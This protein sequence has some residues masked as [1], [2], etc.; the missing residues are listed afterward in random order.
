MDVPSPS[1]KTTNTYKVYNPK[2]IG[3][4]RVHATD[5]IL[6]Y[7]RSRPQKE[8]PLGLELGKQDWQSENETAG[9]YRRPFVYFSY[10]PMELELNFLT[11]K[12]KDIIVADISYMT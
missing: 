3:L 11:N 8:R 9:P 2:D 5:R 4:T 10:V 1:E 12:V 7:L 6:M